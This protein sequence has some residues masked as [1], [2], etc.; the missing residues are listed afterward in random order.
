MSKILR[1]AKREWVS[2]LSKIRLKR[3]TSNY[4]GTQLRIPVIH[5][6]FNGGYIVPAELWMGECLKA[7]VNTKSGVVIDIGVNVGLYLVKLRLI[8]KD[9]EYIGFEPNPF[10]V[11]FTQE[12]IRLNGYQHAKVFPIALSESDGVSRFYASVAGDKAGSLVSSSKDMQAQTHTIDVITM[13]GDKFIDSLNLEA[14]AAIKIDVEEAEIFVLNGL[15]QTIAR[16]RPYIYCEILYIRDDPVRRQRATEIYNLVRSMNYV[17]LGVQ[18]RTGALDV[19]N[20]ITEINTNYGQEYIFCPE[21]LQE[22][23]RESIASA[24]ASQGS[25]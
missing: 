14:I 22:K 24:I 13:A 16:Y 6:V 10:C 3:V 5:G 9:R 4:L 23:F 8:S 2:L 7:F 18:T 1:K 19:I 12:L 20:D 17:V 11:F 25:T 21:E 15:K